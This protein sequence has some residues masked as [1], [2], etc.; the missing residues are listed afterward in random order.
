VVSDIGLPDGDGYA[1]MKELRHHYGL[2][3]IALTGYGMEDDIERGRDAGFVAHLT[4]PV[5]V[6]KLAAVLKHLCPFNS[7]EQIG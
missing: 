7:G 1:L 4:K 6:H 3:G 5:D 2:R